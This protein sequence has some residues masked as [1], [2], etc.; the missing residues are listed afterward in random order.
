MAF[1]EGIH[2]HFLTVMLFDKLQFIYYL[3]YFDELI[4]SNS[5]Q[6]DQIL[7]TKFGMI[8]VRSPVLIHCI[9][10]HKLDDELT[11]CPILQAVEFVWSVQELAQNHPLIHEGQ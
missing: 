5:F 9:L 4:G 6:V 10:V 1:R 8:E 3:E 11:V 2:F 7:I